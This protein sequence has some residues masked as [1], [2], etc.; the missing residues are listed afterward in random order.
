MSTSVRRQRKK[1]SMNEPEATGPAVGLRQDRDGGTGPGPGR[2]GLGARVVGRDGPGAGRCRTTRHVD[3][4]GHGLPRH[5]RPPGRDAASAD[6]RRDPGRPGRSHPTGPTWSASTS[7]RSIS[8]RSTCIRSASDPSIEL[9]DV[10]GPAMLR[11]AAKNH[12]H[13]TVLVDPADY[14][15]VLASSAPTATCPTQTRRALARRA[16]AHTAAYDSAIVALVRRGGAGADRATPEPLPGTVHLSATLAQSLRYGENPHQAG[17]R[18]SFSGDSCWDKAVQ[19]GGKEMSYLN[20][21]DADAAWRLVWS[22]GDRPDRGRDQARQP[23]RRGGRT[24]TS[25]G[26]H[27]GPRVRPDVRLRRHRRRQP[28]DAAGAGRGAGTGVHRGGRRPR[29]RRRRPR[30]AAGRRRT[31]GS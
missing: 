10:G 15:T 9:I 26:L 21:Y 13:V 16:F 8:S 25:P 28:H 12:A 6:P 18:Y 17:A 24:S 27:P 29:L 5:A 14:E 23:V 19:H 4:G 3:R 20:V 7:S 31:C 1:R 22:L 2:A 30:G 11:A